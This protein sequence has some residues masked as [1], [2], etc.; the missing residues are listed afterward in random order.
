[1]WYKH[2]FPCLGKLFVSSWHASEQQ[3]CY[4]EN[5]NLRN[6][7]KMVVHILY[8]PVTCTQKA[9]IAATLNSYIVPVCSLTRWQASW[10]IIARLDF[11]LKYSVH[12][13]RAREDTHYDESKNK[14][15]KTV[16]ERSISDIKPIVKWKL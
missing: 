6:S 1:M 12:K 8:H 14:Q 16:Q 7:G 3:Q 11:K 2:H 4:M 5:K 13:F 10:N 9:I 15:G